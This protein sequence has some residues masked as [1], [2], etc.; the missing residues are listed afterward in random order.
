MRPSIEKLGNTSPKP[1]VT[2]QVALDEPFCAVI[3]A[4]PFPT[5]TTF[6]SLT[7]ATLG[8]ELSQ[9]IESAEEAPLTVSV[10]LSPKIK[11]K[12]DS[13]K[14]K[15]DSMTELELEVPTFSEPQE[16]TPKSERDKRET[17]N[18]AFVFFMV[19]PPNFQGTS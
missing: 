13:L 10:A 15:E 4:F 12:D 3:M 2:E 5:A 1:T 19:K 18:N 16:S 7:E 14:E 9:L 17:V 8:S 6:P 11:S